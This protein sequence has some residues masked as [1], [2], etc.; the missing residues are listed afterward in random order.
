MLKDEVCYS[1]VALSVS[2]CSL[3]DR[4]KGDFVVT[5][6]FLFDCSMLYF[7]IAR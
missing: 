6:R 5:L 2:F 1:S 7:V 4:M 3:V